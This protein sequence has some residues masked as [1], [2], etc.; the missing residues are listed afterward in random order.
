MVLIPINRV[1]AVRIQRA[2]VAMMGAKDRWVQLQL[3]LCG[4]GEVTAGVGSN[5][6]LGSQARLGVA[7]K[8]STAMPVS[9]AVC[10]DAAQGA[11]H[12]DLTTYPCCRQTS[13]CR[14]AGGSTL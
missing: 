12:W 9:A 8:L 7:C 4:E 1:L 10:L 2:S 6:G 11:S 3:L 5:K 13:C 14:P